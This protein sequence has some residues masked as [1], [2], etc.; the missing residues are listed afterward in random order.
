MWHLPVIN[1]VAFAGGVPIAVPRDRI[2]SP[3]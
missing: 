1:D 2:G 3:G